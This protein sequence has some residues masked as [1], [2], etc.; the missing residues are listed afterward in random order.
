MPC[1]TA[2]QWL[3]D[4][5]ALLGQAW[6]VNGPEESQKPPASNHP[7]AAV[8]LAHRHT[9][10]LATHSGVLCCSSLATRHQEHICRPQPKYWRPQSDS[11]L[12]G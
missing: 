2:C 10:G 4:T 3:Q 11:T 6:Q 1:Q 5:C 9:A 8:V 12:M 7:I